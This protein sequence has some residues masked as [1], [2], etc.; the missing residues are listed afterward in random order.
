MFGKYSMLCNSASG[1]E[2]CLPGRVL[3]GPLPGK[4]RNRPSGRPKAGRRADVGAFPGAVR[5]KIRHGRPISGSEALLHNKEQPGN[6]M[7][8]DI[9]GPHLVTSIEG[10]PVHQISGSTRVPAVPE[11]RIY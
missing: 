10:H 2:I 4:H 11:V 8:T 1:P 7:G 5:P 6:A 9:S 3:A